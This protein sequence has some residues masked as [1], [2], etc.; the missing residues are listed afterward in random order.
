LRTLKTFRTREQALFKQT[1]KTLDQLGTRVEFD[2][3]VNTTQKANLLAQIDRTRLWLDFG[4]ALGECESTIHII[5]EA[6]AK[7]RKLRSP[8]DRAAVVL[9]KKLNAAGTSSADEFDQAVQMLGGVF[10]AMTAIIPG[11]VFDGTRVP[12]GNADG[13]TLR[14]TLGTKDGDRNFAKVETGMQFIGHPHHKLRWSVDGL[15][16]RAI[17]GETL[18][19]DHRLDASLQYD[20]FLVGNVI[21]GSYSG[22]NNRGQAVKGS[23]RVA[24]KSSLLL[25]N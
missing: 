16:F 14:F 8:V 22:R 11:M 1:R 5:I 3:S 15:T 4:N 23:F 12:T 17:T 18:K 21:F 10:N 24:L 6:G 20:G 13:A 25:N 19:P 2:K 7:A 9:S